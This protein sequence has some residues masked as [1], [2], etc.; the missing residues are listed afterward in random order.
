MNATGNPATQ[1][2]VLHTKT[3]S[4][5][6]CKTFELV[7]NLPESRLCTFAGV[8]Q[9]ICQGD[10]GGGLTE[11]RQ[12]VGVASWKVPCALGTPDGFERI[13]HYRDWIL[14]I[15]GY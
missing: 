14:E 2:R 3:I 12:L 9:G 11:N 6:E 7:T 13:S 1:L 15:T 10:A 5:E 4:N 8:G